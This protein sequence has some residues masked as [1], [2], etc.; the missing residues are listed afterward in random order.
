M[1]RAEVQADFDRD[2]FT[3]PRVA[4]HLDGDG[5]GNASVYVGVMVGTRY[6]DPGASLGVQM[7]AAPGSLIY[8]LSGTRLVKAIDGW[9][10]RRR[11]GR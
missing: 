9:L 1:K 7:Y 3:L 4:L 10:W 5:E 2:G 8:R 11:F 6:G